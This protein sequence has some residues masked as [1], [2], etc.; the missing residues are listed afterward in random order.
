MSDASPADLRRAVLDRIDDEEIVRLA[1]DLIRIPSFTTEETP[2]AEW[3]AGYLD[4]QGLAVTLQEI[5]PGRKQTI[6]RLAGRGGGRSIMLN[7]HIDI[8]PLASGWTRDPFTPWIADG[9]LFGHGIFNMKGGLTACIMATLALQRARV[10]VRGDVVLA[11]VAAELN[12]GVG[13]LHALEHGARTDMA[14]VAEP[15]GART[16][17]TKHTGT[18]DVV[19]HTIGRATHISKKEHGVDAIAMMMRA[20]AA[21]N[22]M[23][24]THTHDPDLP[25]LPRLNVGSII[26]GRGR[27]HELRGAYTV[28]DFCTAY[29]N[30]RFNASQTGETV[31]ADIRRTLDALSAQDAAFRYEIEFPPRPER[32]LGRLAKA[33]VDVP[34]T[35]PI[36]QMVR[37]NLHDV[38]GAE[39]EHLGVRLPQSYAGNDTTHLWAAGI[40]CC[41]YGPGGGYTD[42]HDVHVDLDDLFLCTRVLA[43]TAL[44]ATR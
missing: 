44:D 39:P 42:Y 31:I 10:P 17:L 7:G 6:A 43:L 20:V 25:G 41:I 38:T 3:L 26:G 24:F 5:E 13:T 14:V 30:V 32:G 16:I 8:D 2:C 21:L 11:C 19:V 28:S 1:G 4:D 35:E 33:A 27:A 29:V 34:K 18:M 15:Y 12:S 40:P 22:A 23:R 36:V 9:K 37:R